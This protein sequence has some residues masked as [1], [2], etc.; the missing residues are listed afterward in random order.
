D[1]GVGRGPQVRRAALVASTAAAKR[2]ATAG[3]T[4]PPKR[5]IIY[6]SGGWILGRTPEPATEDA[7]IN[8]IDKASFRPAHEKLVLD[9]A[10]ENL[11]TSVVRPGVVYGGTEGMARDIFKAAS[12]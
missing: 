7:P 6:R 9:A 8:P 3:A 4:A 10:G 2:P 1:G 11:R 12:N 5:F